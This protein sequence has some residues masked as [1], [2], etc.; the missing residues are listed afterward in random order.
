MTRCRHDGMRIHERL[1]VY[2]DD[3]WSVS[4]LHNS[5]ERELFGRAR[6]RIHWKTHVWNRSS[7]SHQLAM[8]CRGEPKCWMKKHVCGQSE[9]PSIQQG[10]KCW[11]AFWVTWISCGS[12]GGHIAKHSALYQAIPSVPDIQSP[13]LL[14]FHCASAQ[15]N[16]QLRVLRPDVVEH[17]PGPTVRECGNA[18][19]TL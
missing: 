8:S 17:L 4:H 13:W 11:G 15:A 5:V 6:L 16:N 12:V 3:I 9:I 1:F 10:I 2:L 7:R 19:A 18:Y 14:L